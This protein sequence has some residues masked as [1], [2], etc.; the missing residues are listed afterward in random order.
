MLGLMQRV[1]CVWLD[2][3][4]V[5]KRGLMWLRHRLAQREWT[6][7][8]VRAVLKCSHPP[9]PLEMLLE[10]VCV[11]IDMPRPEKWAGVYFRLLA[12]VLGG[13]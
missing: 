6:G 12:A 5:L 2:A 13:N 3:D 4:R 8:S 9:Y 10:A 1:Q 11:A 7:A